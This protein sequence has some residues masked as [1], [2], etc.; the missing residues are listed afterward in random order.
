MAINKAIATRQG[1]DAEHHVLDFV[2]IIRPGGIRME[3]RVN[4]YAN[5][6]VYNNNNEPFAPPNVENDNWANLPQAVKTAIVNLKTALE[7]YYIIKSI[8]GVNG[9]FFGGIRVNDDGSPI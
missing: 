6:T 4:P 5:A 3:C 7:E 2:T 9:M 1:I 8:N